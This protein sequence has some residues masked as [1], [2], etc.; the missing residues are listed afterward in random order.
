[1][2]I[3]MRSFNNAAYYDTYIASSKKMVRAAA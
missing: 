2:E 1:M 3:R